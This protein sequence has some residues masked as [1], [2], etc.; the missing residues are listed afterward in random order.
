MICWTGQIIYE[1]VLSRTRVAPRLGSTANTRRSRSAQSARVVSGDNAYNVGA[2]H[3]DWMACRS[4][5]DFI[6]GDCSTRRSPSGN[7]GCC[8][9]PKRSGARIAFCAFYRFRGRITLTNLLVE[10]LLKPDA[11]AK[12]LATSAQ[13]IQSPAL[14]VE[15]VVATRGISTGLEYFR[16]DFS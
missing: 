15:G 12:G 6:D 1:A 9:H 3:G 16:A 2:G 13:R 8:S 4:E 7:L 10:L 11:D 14:R 5:A